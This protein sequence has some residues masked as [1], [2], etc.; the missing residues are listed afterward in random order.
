MYRK[1]YSN[2]LYRIRETVIPSII[3]VLDDAV[4]SNNRSH[5]HTLL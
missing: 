5:V 1:C 4:L 2:R 3:S